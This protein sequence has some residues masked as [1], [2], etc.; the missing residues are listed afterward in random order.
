MGPAVDLSTQVRT[1]GWNLISKLF[2]REGLRQPG[3]LRA[4]YADDLAL[5]ILLLPPPKCWDYKYTT[6]LGFRL[7]FIRTSYSTQCHTN[8]RIPAL[9]PSYISKDEQFPKRGFDSAQ[10]MGSFCVFVFSFL[11]QGLSLHSPSWPETPVL[12]PLPPHLAP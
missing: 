11:R 5:L 1:S 9:S 8:A 6:T 3:W 2:K 7:L 10:T 12:L 4:L